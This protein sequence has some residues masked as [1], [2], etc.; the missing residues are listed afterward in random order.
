MRCYRHCERCGKNQAWLIWQS[1]RCDGRVAAKSEFT[2]IVHSNQRHQHSSHTW[3]T[4][5]NA[6][7]LVPVFANV[8]TATTVLRLKASSN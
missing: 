7:R 5:L 4:F 8:D 2:C 1:M 6:D 3:Q